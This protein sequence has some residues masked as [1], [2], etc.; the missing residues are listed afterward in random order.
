MSEL[1][2]ATALAGLDG[3][4]DRL[5]H[6]RAL[7]GEFA[8]AVADVPGLRVVRPED[9]DAS[10]YKDLTLVLGPA[11]GLHPTQLQQVLKAEGV[12]SRRYYAPPIHR[13]KAYADVDASH[14]LPVTDRLVESVLSPPAVVAHDLRPGPRRRRA[15]RLGARAR[16][17]P[18]CRP[19][20]TGRQRRLTGTTTHDGHVVPAPTYRR[21]PCGCSSG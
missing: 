20:R 4:E 17:R 6:R 9:G 5:E 1:H 11:Y 19:A 8:G 7:V 2:A 21:A 12:D 13:Q 14:P 18:R 10:T 3:L 16:R 15:G